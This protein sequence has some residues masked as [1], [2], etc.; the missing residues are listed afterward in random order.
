M[1]AA[2]GQDGVWVSSDGGT[3]WRQ[4]LVVPYEVPA[5]NWDGELPKVS[6]DVQTVVEFKGALYAI[7]TVWLDPDGDQFEKRTTAWR[8]EDGEVWSESLI[9]NSEDHQ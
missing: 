7:G 3:S 9:D 8:S 5:L 1:V 4:T 2:A 6:T